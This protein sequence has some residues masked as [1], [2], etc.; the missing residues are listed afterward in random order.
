MKDIAVMN[1]RITLKNPNGDYRT[2]TERFKAS[3]A[4]D[5]NQYGNGCSLEIKSLDSTFNQLFDLRYE[6]D[7]DP[8]H[9]LEYV[10]R[11]AF[12]YWTGEN[13]AWQII[14]IEAS[15]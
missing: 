9:L 11:W 3:V 8:K 10:C 5:P 4:K 15:Y 2:H 7:F 13:G 1:F 12:S 14:A 6:R